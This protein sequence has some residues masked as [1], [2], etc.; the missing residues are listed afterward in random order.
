MFPFKRQQVNI[1]PTTMHRS[2]TDIIICIISLGLHREYFKI[3]ISLKNSFAQ[4][5]ELPFCFRQ[6][7]FKVF[8]D[9]SSSFSAI[10]HTDLETFGPRMP[11]FLHLQQKILILQ[12]VSE[13]KL[14]NTC[15]TLTSLDFN[16]IFFQC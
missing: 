11:V 3:S 6:I 10:Y 12:S 13:V 5:H 2:R 16:S 7:T 8:N 1:V 15:R 4:T 9:L 14:P